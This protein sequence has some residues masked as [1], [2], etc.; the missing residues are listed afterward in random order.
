MDMEK[1]VQKSSPSE[2]ATCA[3]SWG[4]KKKKR[5]RRPTFLDVVEGK[6]RKPYWKRGASDHQ[7]SRVEVGSIGGLNR[8]PGL[9]EGSKHLSHLSS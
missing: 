8:L 5:K 9:N 6:E 3:G 1:A 2:G 4:G 7:G